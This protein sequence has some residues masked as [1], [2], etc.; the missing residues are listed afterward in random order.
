MLQKY[1]S[2]SA[3]FLSQIPMEKRSKDIEYSFSDHDFSDNSETKLLG[4]L[5][6]P[7]G[8]FYTQPS[9]AHLIPKP[10][11][12]HTK[13]SLL[14]ICASISYD[15]L[16]IKEVVS[17]I[18]RLLL[19][20]VMQ[21]GLNWDDD[22]EL[23]KDEQILVIWKQWLQLLPN[24]PL[25][26]VPR[27]LPIRSEVNF[28][29]VVFTDSSSLAH[30]G[31]AFMRWEEKTNPGHFFVRYIYG[32]TK[33]TPLKSKK[34]TLPRKELLS[35]Y[36]GSAIVQKLS[37]A[38]EISPQ[39]FLV[40]NDSQVAVHWCKNKRPTEQLAVFVANRVQKIQ[41]AHVKV[42]WIST[43]YNCADIGTRYD[44]L[45]L[46]KIQK[47][48]LNGENAPFLLKPKSEWIDFN[49]MMPKMNSENKEW[50][51][52]LQGFKQDS[53]L[54][55]FH[56]QLENNCF[57][58][59][60]DDAVSLDKL[61]LVTAY[62][63]KFIEK[64]RPDRA[65]RHS[66]TLCELQDQAHTIYVRITQEQY[67][68]EELA[69]L[70]VDS[71]GEL[72][73]DKRSSIKNLPS[74][75]SIKKLYPQMGPDGTLRSRGRLGYANL[76]FNVKF[77]QIL[78]GKSKL[79]FLILKQAH[80]TKWFSIHRSLDNMCNHA[81]L[82][83][84]ITK[85]RE[86]ARFIIRHCK[87]CN[88]ENKRPA[89][90][91][92]G[93]LPLD[94]TELV[95]PM[96]RCGIDLL[97]P[98]KIRCN[99]HKRGE[100]TFQV[101]VLVVTC[102]VTRYQKFEVVYSL[103]AEDL[104]KALIKM[105][106]EI[107]PIKKIYCDNATNN[108]RLDYEINSFFQDQKTKLQNL[109]ARRKIDFVYSPPLSPHY[110]GHTEAAVRLAKVALRKTFGN[111]IISESDLKL[112]LSAAENTLN[113]RPLGAFKS[114]QNTEKYLLTPKMLLLAKSSDVAFYDMEH[115]AKSNDISA[116]WRQR[117]ALQTK[118]AKL[119]ITGYVAYLRELSK[120]YKEKENIE[121]GTVCLLIDPGQKHLKRIHYP[122]VRVENLSQDYMGKS[123]TA[124][125]TLLK[126][127]D[128]GD[129]S[130]N[131][132][133]TKGPIITRSIHNLVPLE[134]F[135]CGELYQKY[136]SEKLQSPKNSSNKS[137]QQV[138]SGSKSKKS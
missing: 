100:N 4:L 122:L 120:W 109:A 36:L 46:E 115:H 136:A 86:R 5:Y 61:V 29:I 62:V 77:P 117:L 2:N 133:A 97:G 91:I 118:F 13:R 135:F 25:L 7:K 89:G 83:T 129:A 17:L 44:G 92:L 137:M 112:C 32:K 57:K 42:N 16:G 111:E 48:W 26:K 96:E 51:Q 63:L 123:R 95:D 24:T 3:K 55:N 45:S 113:S 98:I 20:R 49:S 1:K 39:D 60:L 108:H 94:R 8:D 28:E 21:E 128:P 130:K 131:I 75:S 15:P 66:S 53:V 82:K 58:T 37:Q 72:A 14:S 79:S 27:F 71:K 121:K 138:E 18:G 125:L 74:H 54:T 107:G 11:A 65:K 87:Q 43:E 38:Y 56:I 59:L 22:L 23:C 126:N 64:I 105:D 68:H 35:C 67:Y 81:N 9:Y 110:L 52:Y 69:I 50:Q 101:Y 73:K 103:S 41:E 33:V 93:S 102:M 12:K 40:F 85:I 127:Y 47:I 88:I 84:H 70:S 124:N 34:L 30:A 99:L 134:A 106:N 10:N 78:P 76:D 6:N 19:Q 119:F 114:D 80:L 90:Q 116:R 132:L 31:L 104:I